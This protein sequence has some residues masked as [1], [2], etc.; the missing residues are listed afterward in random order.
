MNIDQVKAIFAAAVARYGAGKDAIQATRTE[1]HAALQI[2]KPLPFSEAAPECAAKH[3]KLH[4]HAEAE[5]NRI[6]QVNQIT[7]EELTVAARAIA[8]E[9]AAHR[10]TSVHHYFQRE[11]GRALWEETDALCREAGVLS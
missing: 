4:T 1:V 10:A 9:P 5:L 3:G 7:D 6:H 8:L 11:H 2:E